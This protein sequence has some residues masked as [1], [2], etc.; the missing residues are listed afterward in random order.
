MCN[1]FVPTFLLVKKIT[2]ITAVSR[3]A[4]ESRKCLNRVNY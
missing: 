2:N 3:H 1:V 4:Q